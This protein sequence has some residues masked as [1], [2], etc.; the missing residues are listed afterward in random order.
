MRIGFFKS[1]C[2]V[3]QTSGISSSGREE[4]GSIGGWKLPAAVMI[5]ARRIL[6]YVAS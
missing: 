3:A 1:F 2:E 6:T 5:C 4:M